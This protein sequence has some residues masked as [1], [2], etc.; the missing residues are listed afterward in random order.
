MTPGTLRVTKT[1]VFFTG[2]TP[3]DDPSGSGPAGDPSGTGP[4]QG[5]R[6]TRTFKRWPVAALVEVHHARF[7]L[8][9]SAM[10]LFFSDRSSAMLNFES[11]EV[12]PIYFIIIYLFFV[13][14][15]SPMQFAR[16]SCFNVVSTGKG[17]SKS[18]IIINASTSSLGLHC[19]HHDHY[20]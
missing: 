20:H 4:R 11:A 19:Y 14:A 8:Q 15:L 17:T 6:G 3:P 13:I 1:N 16:F 7:L 9:P 2:E 12:S 18:L 10:E 5:L